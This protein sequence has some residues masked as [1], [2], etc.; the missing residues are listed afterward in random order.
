MGIAPVHCIVS[1]IELESY[2]SLL[3]IQ[4]FAQRGEHPASGWTIL[5]INNTALR[6]IASLIVQLATKQFKTVPT[7]KEGIRFLMEFDKTLD[8]DSLLRG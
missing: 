1:L 4:K 5:V 6:F 3:E 7:L 2:P 8:K